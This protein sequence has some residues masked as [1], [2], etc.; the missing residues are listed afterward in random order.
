MN[1]VDV[2]LRFI[3]YL[4]IVDLIA[5][6]TVNQRPVISESTFSRVWI[7]SSFRAS[8]GF[9]V[10][11]MKRITHTKSTV[12]FRLVQT[13]EEEK[14]AFDGLMRVNLLYSHFNTF[15]VVFGK[16]AEI[17]LSLRRVQKQSST[18]Q[19]EEQKH[20]H[21]YPVL[22]CRFL[23]RNVREMQTPRAALRLCNQEVFLWRRVIFPPFVCLFLL[24]LPEGI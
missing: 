6:P 20:G 4:S 5:D 8:G 22:K 9:Q 1:A 23:I 13:P 24:S 14:N 7:F 11:V 16:F 15:P 2:R 12:D 3:L 17:L 18:D 19:H 10:K 21:L